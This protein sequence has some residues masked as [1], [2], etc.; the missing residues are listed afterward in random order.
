MV[1]F[2]C[3]LSMIKLSIEIIIEGL[4]KFD[5]VL[6]NDKN[7]TAIPIV[8]LWCTQTVDLSLLATSI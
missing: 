4:M 7:R 8:Y 1:F 6:G 2:K 3:N 5:D